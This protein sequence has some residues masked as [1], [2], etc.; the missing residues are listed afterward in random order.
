MRDGDIVTIKYHIE[1][2]TG[3]SYT[4][5]VEATPITVDCGVSVGTSSSDPIY[6]STDYVSCSLNGPDKFE[7]K[8]NRR[9]GSYSSSTYVHFQ[10]E[11]SH[12]GN[13]WKPFGQMQYSSE[14]SYWYKNNNYGGLT[15]DN[16][17]Y[18]GY[19]KFLIALAQANM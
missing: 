10:V 9:S 3:G 19:F 5:F 11:I 6:F 16:A 1:N 4:S 17:T 13:I 18:F 12:D 15:G 7:L 2:T 8:V 14:S